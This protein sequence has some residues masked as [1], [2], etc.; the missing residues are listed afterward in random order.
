VCD[1]IARGAP[2]PEMEVVTVMASTTEWIR[3]H[4]QRIASL[5]PDAPFGD[6]QLLHASA[7]TADV[8]GLG[9]STH[10]AHEQFALKHRMVRLLVS[11]LGFRSLALEE[12]WTKGLEIDRYIVEGDGDIRVIVADAGIPW[13]TEEIL[14]TIEWLRRYND[15]HRADPVRFVGVDIVAVRAAAYDAVTEYVRRHAPE[16]ADDLRR[17]FDP[18]HPRGSAFQ[19]IQWYRSVQDKQP[20]VEHAY[21]A[22]ALVNELPQAD[23]HALALQHA[24]AIIGFYEYHAQNSVALRDQ[25]MA[26]NIVWWQ[27]RTGHKV[28]YWAANVHTANAPRLTIS[29]PPFP[30]TTHATAGSKLRQAYGD[31]YLSVGCVF[32]H[33]TVNAGFAPPTAH[34]VPTPPSDFFE[35]VFAGIAPPMEDFIVDLRTH[36]AGAHWLTEPAKTRVI[37]PAYDH[38][39]DGAYWMAGG[40]LAEWFDV[41]VYQRKVSPTH[42]LPQPQQMGSR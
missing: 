28:A 11:E 27:R 35:A 26:D 25:R 37:G 10:G 33:G 3:T 42:L 40:S 30:P 34:D 5:E 9:E 14:A 21:Q 4:A 20:L 36:A 13:R 1:R 6:L 16:R 29:Y 8:V 17:H 19:H 2:S 12:D 24:R 41:L 38:K 31:K 22:Y 23:G 32:D 18:I 39:Q 15:T 7:S